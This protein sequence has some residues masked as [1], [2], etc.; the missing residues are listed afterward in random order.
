MGGKKTA[1]RPRNSCIGQIQSDAWVKIFGELKEKA[2]N[3]AEWR[4]EIVNR[5]TG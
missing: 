1:G 4:N 5:L 3:R 2:S